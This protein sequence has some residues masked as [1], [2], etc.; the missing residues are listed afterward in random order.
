MF[1]LL[2]A[3]VTGHGNMVF[4]PTWQD[5]FGATQINSF[6]T[7]IHGGC[8]WFTND[9]AA[10]E[11]TLDYKNNPELLTYRDG[12]LPHVQ[13][14]LTPW[15]APGS[16]FIYSPCGIQGGNPLG[17]PVGDEGSSTCPGGGFAFGPDARAAY[18]TSELPNIVATKWKSG[19]VVEAH[20]GIIANHGGGYQ[21]RICKAPAEGM[22]ALTEECFQNG[23]L[24]FASEKSW[25]QYGNDTSKRVEFEAVRTNIGTTP[26]GS[27]WARNP[28]PA[29]KGFGGGVF[30]DTSNACLKSG[31]TQFEPPA[32]GVQGFGEYFPLLVSTFSFNIVDKL[33]LPNLDSGKYVL[34]FRWDCGQTTQIWNTCSDIEIVA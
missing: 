33:Q 17:C 4:P 16:A 34:S 31:G 24:E 11:V 3:S 13:N 9:T 28:V 7:C 23:V 19:S 15:M 14:G 26:K 2:F 8:M 22:T 5:Q 10:K 6:E 1:A 27:T 30:S 29:C 32:P 12:P 21:Y 20:W 25:I 18:G